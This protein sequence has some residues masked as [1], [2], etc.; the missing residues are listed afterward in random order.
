MNRNTLDKK[1]I[2]NVVESYLMNN[3]VYE[4][5]SKEMAEQVKS[6]MVEN[7]FNYCR[8]LRDEDEE[9]YEYI[10]EKPRLYQTELLYSII[11]EEYSS[12]S[13]DNSDVITEGVVT[14]T[15]L[16][17]LAAALLSYHKLF[18]GGKYKNLDRVLKRINQM[19]DFLSN[20]GKKYRVRHMVIQKNTDECYRKCNVSKDHVSNE[21]FKSVDSPEKSKNK[22]DEERARCLTECFCE[23]YLESIKLIYD[24]YLN[25]LYQTTGKV[26]SFDTSASDKLLNSIQRTDLIEACS[27]YRDSFERYLKDY[28]EILEVIYHKD[29]NKH[30]EKLNETMSAIGKITAKYKNKNK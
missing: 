9:I 20:L 24:A 11:N 28:L 8:T 29:N 30:N 6:I 18:P 4:E 1:F 26:P 5:Y 25:C 19:G 23:N 2:T 3:N 12:Y 13:K 15:S 27:P 22:L 21:M 7:V 10:I 14:T 17:I 16:G